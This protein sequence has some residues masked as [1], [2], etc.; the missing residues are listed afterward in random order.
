MN[1]KLGEN[2]QDPLFRLAEKKKTQINPKSDTQLNM[3]ELAQVFNGLFGLIYPQER[4][5]HHLCLQSKCSAF[6]SSALLSQ[7]GCLQSCCRSG[8]ELSLENAEGDLL[9][10]KGP[11]NR[12]ESL[13]NTH[14]YVKPVQLLEPLSPNFPCPAAEH[15][16]QLLSRSAPKQ[17]KRASGKMLIS[18][19]TLKRDGP[20]TLL[21]QRHLSLSCS[22]AVTTH[23]HQI[24]CLPQSKQSFPLVPKPQSMPPEK[25]S[26]AALGHSGL[27][28]I[29]R[30]MS[31][32]TCPWISFTP[33]LPLSLWGR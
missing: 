30:L 18:A 5:I 10:W 12:N 23:T 6:L 20:L 26:T 31:S 28:K 27:E 25:A 8:K 19:T 16:G 14:T 29:N 24:C 7:K 21:L 17:Y 3:W 15:P 33:Q 32:W 22:S 4:K 11:K 13:W 1:R 9:R 2:E